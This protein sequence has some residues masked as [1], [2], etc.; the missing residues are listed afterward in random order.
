MTT[1]KDVA[2]FLYA[3]ARK[4]TGFWYAHPLGEVQGLTEEQLFWVPEPKSLCMLWH[5][6]HIAHRERTHIGKFLQ[7]L[8]G[9]VIPPHYEAFGT[10]WC[11]VEQLRESIDSVS[12]VF[13]WVDQ[14]RK[15]SKEFITSLSERDLLNVLPSSDFG[16]GLSIAHWLL[17]TVSHGAIHI[18]R[19]QML[20]AMLEGKN[21]RPC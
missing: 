10:E 8:E 5:V 7:G 20:R 9:E 1:W 15:D 19:I 2:Q 11:A 6:G 13:E 14:V 21:D 12:Q 3:D 16:A 18:G 4:D 17:I